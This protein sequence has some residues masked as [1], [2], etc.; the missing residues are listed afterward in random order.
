M[1]LNKTTKIVRNFWGCFYLVADKWLKD[2]Q[3]RQLA[4]DDLT[5]YQKIIVALQKTIELMA[6]I[7]Q[8]IPKWPIE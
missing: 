3:G 1:P 7:D 6:K 8:A 4:Y 5:H 2:W